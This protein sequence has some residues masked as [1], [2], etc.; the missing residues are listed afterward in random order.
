MNVPRV[1]FYTKAGCELCEHA[2]AVVLR[3][4]RRI[5]FDL[6]QVDITADPELFQRYRYRIPVVEIDGEEVFDLTVREDRLLE[7]LRRRR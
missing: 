7:R 3:A 4:Q 6:E 1:R 2:L 5:P